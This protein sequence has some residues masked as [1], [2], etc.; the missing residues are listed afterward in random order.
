MKTKQLILF[1]IP[2]LCPLAANAALITGIS[3]Q[4]GS[5]N[6]FNPEVMGPEKAING[7]GLPGGEPT[8]SGAHST[9]FSHQWW[10]FPFNETN[11]AQLTVN[12]NDPYVLS[13][14]QV[15]N[16]NEAGVTVRGIQNVGIFVSPD[17]DPTNLVKLLTDG[18]GAHDNGAGDFLF[19]EAP[20]ANDYTGFEVDLSG[21]TNA[22]LLSNVRLVQLVPVDSYDNSAGVGL[23]EIQFGGILVPE[24]SSALLSVFAGLALLV[25]RRH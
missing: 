2:A 22:S 15:W 13:T 21:V 8:L 10:S 1:A 14:I 9:T 12:L 6:P 16:Y 17:E 4:S 11:P 20:G 3:V 7:D 25:R 19:P 24:P 23:A 5:T 18:T